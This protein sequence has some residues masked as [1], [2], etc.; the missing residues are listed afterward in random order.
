MNA[1]AHSH[2]SRPSLGLANNARTHYLDLDVGRLAYRSFGAEGSTP[3]LFTQR[4]RGTIDEWD[5]A[6]LDAIA[7]ERRVILFDSAGVGL[8]SGTTPGTIAEMA[9]IA[10]S[11]VDALGV[12]EVDVLGW[13]MGGTVAQRLARSRPQ[14]VRR[15]VLAGT[16]PGGLR[17]APRPPVKV[18]EVASKPVNDDE[19]FLYLFFA[20]SPSSR[21]LGREHLARLHQRGEPPVPAVRA[22]SFMS[23]W[24]AIAAW[25]AGQDSGPDRLAEIRQPTL[26]ANGVHD[27][28]VDAYSSYALARGIS[29][30]ELVLYRDA[31]HGFL[32]QQ[33]E[34]FARLVLDFLR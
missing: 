25:T 17:D 12:R 6:L 22:P 32:F 9:N 5:P 24:Q 4:F 8:S 21:A 16:G 33:P 29:D 18:A 10:A 11:F 7:S 28:M 2:K 26:V 13:S 1:T 23:Q 15:L 31:G 27:V 3:L 19:D 14:L 30:A 20:D 34:R